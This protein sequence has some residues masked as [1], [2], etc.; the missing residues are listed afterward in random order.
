MSKIKTIGVVTSGGCTG[1]NAAVRAVVRAGIHYG[2]SI[3]GVRKGYE[4]LCV[5]ILLKMSLRS[6]GDIIHR[7]GTSLQTARSAEFAT[8]EGVK[9]VSIAKVFGM[10]ALIVIG[11]DGSFR[12]LWI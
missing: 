12:G 7:G 3:L 2:F 6:V 1:M 9:G 5:V 4:G 10:D 8:A 11:G